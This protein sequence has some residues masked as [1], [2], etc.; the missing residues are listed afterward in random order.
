[1][2]TDL[3]QIIRSS[4]ALSSDHYQYFLF[5]LLHG[6]KNIYSVNIHYRDLK[7]ENLLVNANCELKICNFGLTCTS[8]GK[9]QF[10]TEYIV[11]CWYRSPELLLCC[12][13]YDTSID[14]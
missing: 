1:M 8:S 2:D 9:V 12:D 7:P 6:L 14:V 11:A 3:H 5:Q 4:Q 10:M 13:N